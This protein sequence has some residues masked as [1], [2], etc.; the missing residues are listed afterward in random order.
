METVA[1][2]GTRCVIEIATAADR[3]PAAV[4]HLRSVGYDVL[5]VREEP[6]IHRDV[7]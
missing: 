3:A 1:D 5:G 2:A 6:V 4:A 7:P